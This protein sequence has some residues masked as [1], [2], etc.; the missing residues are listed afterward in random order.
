[1]VII[2]DIDGT[3]CT[4]QKDYSKA[5]PI[6]SAIERINRLFSLGHKIIL[7]TARGATTRIDWKEVTEKQLKDWG[8]QYNELRFDKPHYD[9]WIDDKAREAKEYFK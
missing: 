2:C 3:L 9:L 1:M 4:Q 6:T 5:E 7:W 8:V